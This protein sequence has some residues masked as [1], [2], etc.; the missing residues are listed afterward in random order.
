M[1]LEWAVDVVEEASVAAVE[2][3]AVEDMDSL[4]QAT[5][6]AA[7]DVDAASALTRDV[8]GWKD[9]AWMLRAF[10][11]T[12]F[13]GIWDECSGGRWC[14]LWRTRIWEKDI[15]FFVLAL[16]E[17]PSLLTSWIM[18]GPIQPSGPF[19]RTGW[20]RV[21]GVCVFGTCVYEALSHELCLHTSWADHRHRL[22][23]TPP[24]NDPTRSRRWQEEK[25]MESTFVYKC[26]CEHADR[27]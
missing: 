7:V 9:V 15:K 25:T 24:V 13:F 12:S 10:N 8:R 4:A 2:D 1:S 3:L 6:A 16:V 23:C 14:W 20:R 5:V 19:W 18:N 27:T 21:I 17:L 11:I 22:L 26:T